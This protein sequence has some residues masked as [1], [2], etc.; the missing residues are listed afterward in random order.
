MQLLV[1]SLFCLGGGLA[2]VSLLSASLIAVQHVQQT[3]RCSP[4]DHLNAPFHRHP[5]LAHPNRRWMEVLGCGMVDPRVL[6]MAGVDP[7]EYT[8]FAAGFGVERFA[9][10]LF[11][12]QD[13]RNFWNSDMRF[14]EQFPADI[15]ASFRVFGHCALAPAALFF[16]CFFS[17]LLSSAAGGQLFHLEGSRH[18]GLEHI[19]FF[20]GREPLGVAAAPRKTF[21]RC[22]VEKVGCGFG[23]ACRPADPLFCQGRKSF[24]HRKLVVSRW[25]PK[26]E[27]A[28]LRTELGGDKFWERH[29]RGPSARSTIS[30]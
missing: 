15:Q 12:V 23:A 11:G 17:V 9:M 13:L 18:D 1:F 7:E 20:R 27:E 4:R 22:G 8:G 5:R 6:E 3:S 19:D 26:A 21:P 10:V 28:D 14:L 29:L 25:C 16:I 24:P 2:V 30:G